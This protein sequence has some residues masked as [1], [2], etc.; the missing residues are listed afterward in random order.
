MSYEKVTIGPHALYRGDCLEVLPTLGRVD[1]TVTSPPYNVGGNN[2]SARAKVKYTSAESDA[3]PENEWE[4]LIEDSLAKSLAISSTVFLNIQ[5]LSS[6]KQAVARVVGRNSHQLKDRIV[7]Y[8]TNAPASM[9]PGVLDSSFEDIWIFSSHDAKRRK[10][11]GAEW[12]GMRR[13]VIVSSVHSANDNAGEHRATF[14]VHVP[15]FCIETDEACKSVLDPFMG[16]GTT[17]VACVRTGR[18]FIGIEIDKGYFDIA[19]RRITDEMNNTALFDGEIK[20][21]QPEL[22]E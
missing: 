5:S 3:I 22:F 19:C 18:K 12:R 14:P 4:Q 9:E 16:S 17:G 20:P 8:K 6:N 13:S 11:K 21:T 2:M 15:T 7:W 1:C 10:F